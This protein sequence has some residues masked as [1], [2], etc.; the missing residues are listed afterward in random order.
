MKLKEY[1]K[2]DEWKTI[3]CAVYLDADGKEI[4]PTTETKW[5]RMNNMEIVSVEK[6]TD[7]RRIT[8]AIF[9]LKKAVRL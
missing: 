4:D 6:S 8:T 1:R 7:D 3:D 5:R 9:V 2:T